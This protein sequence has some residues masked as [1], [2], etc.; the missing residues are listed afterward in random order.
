MTEQNGSK[1]RIHPR[2]FWTS[3]GVILLF[4]VFALLNLEQMKSVFDAAQASITSSAGWFFVASVNVYL[5][6]VVYIIFSRHGAIRLGGESATPEFT[7][8]GWASMLFS[9]G[10][11]IGLVFWSVAEPIYHFSSPPWGGPRTAA[12]AE[13]A[14]AVTYFHWGF[15]AWGLYALMALGLAYFAYN[16]GQALTIRSVFY[17]LLGDRI[18]GWVGDLIDILAAVATLFGLATSLGLGAQQVNAGLDFLLGISQGPTEQILLIGGITAM[19][20]VSV[21]L[22]L[23]RGIRRLSQLNMVIALALLVFVAIAGPSLALLDALVQNVGV[24]LTH[25]PKLSLWTE[26]YSRGEWQHGWT[27]FYWAWWIAWAPFVGIFIARISKGRTIR[28]FLIGVLV[29]PTTMTFVW[30][31]IFGNS[32][33]FGELYGDGGIVE[34]V[35]A[36]VATALFV[37]LETFPWATLA[38][39]LSVVVITLFFVT[40]SDSASLVIDIITAGGH[41][42]PPTVQRVFW[43]VTEGVVAAVL[44]LGGGLAAL[45]TGVIITG[46]P[47]AVVL[48]LVGVSLLKGL[49]SDH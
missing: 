8:W 22:G 48:L 32:A 41:P 20:T 27:V 33:L 24:Y 46:L 18:H 12:A 37:L 19:A 49:N 4:V 36:N 31:T 29:V 11:G 21:V 30:L 6:F 15:H 13:L 42:D 14:M 39:A 26:A 40:S 5:G 35:N 23:D 3:A 34:A 7:M 25:L 17:P 38:S 45:Q 1:L 28:E 16:R 10:M 43:A 47:F 44:L 2:V 9:A